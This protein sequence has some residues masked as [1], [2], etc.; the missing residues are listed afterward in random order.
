MEWLRENGDHFFGLLCL[1]RFKRSRNEFWTISSLLGLALALRTWA[2]GS[3]NRPLDAQ[4]NPLDAVVCEK[5]SFKKS[6]CCEET[7]RVQVDS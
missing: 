7:S 3:V 6:F 5:W 4:S 1:I 2:S